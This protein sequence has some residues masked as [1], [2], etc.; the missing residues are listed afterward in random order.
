MKYIEE[1]LVGS[2]FL[3]KNNYYILTADFKS[4]HQKLCYDLNSGFPKWIFGDTIVDHIQIYTMDEKNT[5]IP[6]KEIKK[7]DDV[8]IS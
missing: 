7:E 8:I 6:I 2:C 5:I 4:N 1:L 3:Y